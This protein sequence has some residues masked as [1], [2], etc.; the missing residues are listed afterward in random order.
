MRCVYRISYHLAR[1][2]LARRNNDFGAM[3]GKAF[4]HRAAD[5]T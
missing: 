2:E 4:S 1:L 5:A 3:L